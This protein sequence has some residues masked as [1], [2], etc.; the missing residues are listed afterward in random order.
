MYS[1]I[2][3]TGTGRINRDEVIGVSCERQKWR[4]WWDPK[5]KQSRKDESKSRNEVKEITTKGKKRKEKELEASDHSKKSSKSKESK[6]AQKEKLESDQS[7]SDGKEESDRKESDGQED[8]DERETNTRNSSSEGFIQDDYKPPR[9]SSRFKIWKYY[10]GILELRIWRGHAHAK[11]LFINNQ[12]KEDNRFILS[13]S[14][15]E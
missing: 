4:G 2:N 7:E 6:H 8:S 5:S 11:N 9:H 10:K 13:G 12:A 3:M 1:G 14:D 15:S